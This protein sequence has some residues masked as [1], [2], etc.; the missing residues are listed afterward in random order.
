MQNLFHRWSHFATKFIDII[1][2]KKIKFV[3]FRRITFQKK[4]LKCKKF[5]DE[6]KYR[7]T[8]NLLYSTKSVGPAP[9]KS[10]STLILSLNFSIFILLY[11]VLASM[12]QDTR[13]KL[14]SCMKF[15]QK[16][17]QY[18]NGSE[19]NKISAPYKADDIVK[20]FHKIHHLPDPLV[21]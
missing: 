11:L 7:K 4:V 21:F 10:N 3:C 15:P 14:Q 18:K 9:I 6:R 17:R 19:I 20:Y 1:N 13:Q 16:S 8:N 5:E 2:C 12:T